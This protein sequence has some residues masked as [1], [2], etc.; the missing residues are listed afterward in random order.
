MHRVMSKVIVIV[1]VAILASLAPLAADAQNRSQ[2]VRPT[3]S[4]SRRRALVIGDDNYP[5]RPL[6]NSVNDAVSVGATLRDLGFV[7]DV[8]LNVSMIQMEQAADRFVAAVRP[9]DT[10][11]FYY[12]G[13]GMQFG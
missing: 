8:Q 1:A 4:S 10:A 12:S 3:D 7:A 11:L 2:G 9:G 6:R 13:H 5:D